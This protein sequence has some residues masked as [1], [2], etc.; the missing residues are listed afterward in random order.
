MNLLVLAAI[1][2]GVAAAAVGLMYAIRRWAPDDHFF[3]EVERGTGVFA[4]VGTA[5]TVLLAFV[6]L[7]AFE[8]FNDVKTG[9]ETEAT[10]ILELSRTAEFFSRSERDRFTGRLICYARAVVDDEWPAMR[11][12]DRSPLV[13]RWVER[14]VQTVNQIDV[15]TPRQEAAF[16]QLLQQESTRG[17]GRRVRLSEA[18]RTLPAP[19][20]FILVLGAMLTIGFALLFADRRERFLVQASIIAPVAALVTAGLLLIWFL[21]HPYAGASGSIEPTE[22]RTQLTITE[23]EQADVPVPCNRAG[24]PTPG[25]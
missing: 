24:E 15:R 10:S 17:E 12:G 18:I 22:M 11:D 14:I 8:S 25:S 3:V 4:F 21:D 5:F 23:H 7:V 13:Q 9:A 19:V 16:L 6:V 20:W 2:I 1:V